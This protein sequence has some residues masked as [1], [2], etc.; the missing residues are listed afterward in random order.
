MRL[1]FFLAAAEICLFLLA[2]AGL[3]AL[4]EPPPVGQTPHR[5]HRFPARDFQYLLYLPQDYYQNPN[6]QY[7]LMLFLHGAGERG[8][9]LDMLKK[10]GPP[11]LAAAGKEFPF[12]IVSPQ[13]RENARWKTELLKR[14]LDDVMRR[15]RVARSRI[16]LTGLSMGGFGTWNLAAAYPEYFAAMIPI[17]G[18]GDPDTAGR[19]IDIP[20]WA[21]HGAKDQVVPVEGQQ[22]MVDALRQAGG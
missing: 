17:C 2:C 11:K 4:R 12:L 10:H 6:R 20:V 3:S 13:C 7:P 18:S 14:L 19:L 22:R 16:Y 8:D 1:R 5:L 15:Y 9:T 21:F